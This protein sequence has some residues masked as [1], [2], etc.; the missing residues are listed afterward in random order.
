MSKAAI[1]SNKRLDKSNKTKHKELEK[2]L[3]ESAGNLE[4]SSKIDTLPKVPAIESR[5]E[6]TTPPEVRLVEIEEIK[7]PEGDLAPPRGVERLM[8]SLSLNGM[9]NLPTLDSDLTILSGKSRI[10]AAKRLGW[11]KV[12]A[13]ILPKSLGNM[14]QEERGRIKE[15][16]RHD[17][18]LV[19][20]DLSFIDECVSLSRQKE[21]Y[22]QYFPETKQGGAKGKAGGGKEPKK[23]PSSS[24][25]IAVA[26][27]TNQTDRNAND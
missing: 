1:V 10:T 7:F 24:F 15:L 12:P 3:P 26:G 8:V 19:R 13:I 25:A 16:M 22:L 18:N 21:I 9:I 2:I 17:E 11:K 14:T 20:Q 5:M 23:E 4:D 6:P 27:A